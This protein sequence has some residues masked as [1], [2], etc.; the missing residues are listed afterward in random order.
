MQNS[1]YFCPFKY[2]QKSKQKVW[3]ETEN[4]ERDWGER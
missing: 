3:S 2:E 4:G 1:P